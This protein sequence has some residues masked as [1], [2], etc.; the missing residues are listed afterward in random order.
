VNADM[1]GTALSSVPKSVHSYYKNRNAVVKAPCRVGPSSDRI[2]P[3][4]GRITARVACSELSSSEGYHK[5]VFQWHV[6]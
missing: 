2:Q 6:C 4:S 1:K 3:I 5:C